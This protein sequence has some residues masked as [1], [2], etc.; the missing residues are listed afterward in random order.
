MAEIEILNVKVRQERG[1]RTSRKLRASGRLP[2]VVYGDKQ[3]TVAVTVSSDE[4]ASLLR[5]AAHVVDLAGDLEGKALIKD[6]QW[7]TYGHEVLHLDL[8]R[9][10][11]DERVEVELAV[12][13]RGTAPGVKQGGVVEQHL[14]TVNLECPVLAVPEKIEVNINHLELGQQI[15]AAELNLPEGVKLLDSADATVVECR[16][17]AEEQEEVAEAAAEPELIGRKPEEEGAEASD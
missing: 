2:A 12:D 10:R 8:N 3:D 15:T 6:M 14:H 17:P 5:H 7:D 13:L 9:V 11:A 1:T 4:V 16:E